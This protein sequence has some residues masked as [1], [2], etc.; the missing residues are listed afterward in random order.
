MDMD[1]V[2]TQV[3]VIHSDVKSIRD[4]QELSRQRTILEWISPINYPAQQSD[5]LGRRQ[6]GTGQWFLDAHETARW[7]NEP[8]ATLF[9]PGI[10]GAGKTMIA[11]IAIDHLQ[12]FVQNSSHGVA[13]VYCNYKDKEQ[14]IASI[15]TAVM[16]QL[17]QG[18][19]SA[20]GSAERLYQQ[21]AGRGRPSL[22]EIHNALLDVLGHYPS[23]YIVVDA[24]DECPYATRCLFLAELRALQAVQDIRIMA[25]SR[26]NL[27][28]QDTFKDALKLEV[29]ASNE[30]VK[31]FVASQIY[32]L[33]RCIQRD[34]SLQKMVQEKIVEAVD[35]M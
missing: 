7:L 21:H 9:C 23:V 34:A 6:E 12:K 1:C 16:K 10:P 28:I 4:E 30:D 31:R 24:L 20:I 15:L 19:S 8:K 22:D 25:T 18:R 17:I 2:R 13:Y 3:P 29:R 5:I 14:D 27:D 32:K 35:G 11:A 33:P 26:F